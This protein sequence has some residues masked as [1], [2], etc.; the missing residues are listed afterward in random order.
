MATLVIQI[1]EKTAQINSV[2]RGQIVPN[3]TFGDEVGASIQ[4]TSAQLSPINSVS[5]QRLVDDWQLILLPVVS[6]HAYSIEHICD[7]G[8]TVAGALLR[9]TTHGGALN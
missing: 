7:S 5:T 3:A 2:C 6:E 9:A 4:R 1:V 8:K